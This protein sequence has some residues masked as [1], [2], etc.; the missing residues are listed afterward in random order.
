MR[1]TV[2]AV[3]T[4]LPL[5]GQVP[6]VERS[7]IWVDTVKSGELPLLVRGPG[8]LAT[9]KT[10]GENDRPLMRTV[11]KIGQSNPVERIGEKSGHASLLGQP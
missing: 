3:V 7:A 10:A 11:G 8:V 2:L 5:F 1:R 6:I 4:L 9:E